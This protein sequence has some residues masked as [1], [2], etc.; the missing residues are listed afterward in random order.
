M[1]QNRSHP[2][3]KFSFDRGDGLDLVLL[4]L[5]QFLRDVEQRLERLEVGVPVGDQVV[6]EMLSKMYR[7]F[8]CC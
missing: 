7:C 5:D 8:H 4:V 2:R 3:N 1:Q 6:M